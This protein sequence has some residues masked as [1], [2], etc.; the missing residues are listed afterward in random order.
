[1]TWLPG[2]TKYYQISSCGLYT[3]CAIGG[4]RGLT[5]ESWRLKEQLAVGF[6]EAASAKAHCESHFS[7]QAAK[8]A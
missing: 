4:A 3:V 5:Y 8:A 2:K 7:Q 6:Q 1:M